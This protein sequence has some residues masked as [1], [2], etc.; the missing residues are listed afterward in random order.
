MIG[1]CSK[2]LS[3][4]GDIVP[5]EDSNRRAVE[6]T[7]NKWSSQGKRVILLA[8]KTIP[9]EQMASLSNASEVEDKILQHSRDGLILIG[10][11]GIVDPPREEIPYVISTLRRAGIRIFMVCPAIIFIKQSPLTI[12]GHWRLCSHSSGCRS[13]VWHYHKHIRV[14]EINHCPPSRLC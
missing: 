6:E 5:L 10:I 4:N 8:R 14:C 3:I 13:R 7:K 1:Q 12:I 2:L 11:V 9:K